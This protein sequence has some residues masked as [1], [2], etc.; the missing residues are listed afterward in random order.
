MDSLYDYF[1]VIIVGT[2]LLLSAKLSSTNLR[3]NSCVNHVFFFVG[4]L[5]FGPLSNIQ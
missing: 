1:N 3:E 5:E 2:W 4:S